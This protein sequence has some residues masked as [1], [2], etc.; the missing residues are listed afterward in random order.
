MG[1]INV[2]GKI[3]IENARTKDGARRIF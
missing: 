1:T 2:N 3:L